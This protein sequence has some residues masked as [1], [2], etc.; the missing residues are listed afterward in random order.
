MSP[1]DQGVVNHDAGAHWVMEHNYLHDNGGAALILGDDNTARYNCFDH[2]AQYGFQIFGD[3]VTAVV[4][5]GQSQRLRQ[6]RKLQPRGV[7]APGG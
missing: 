1:L 5:R 7:G 6:R 2:N 3:T 4:Q